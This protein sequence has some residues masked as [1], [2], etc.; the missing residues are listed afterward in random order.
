MFEFDLIQCGLLVLFLMVLGEVI[1]HK[2][3]AVVPSILASAVLYLILVWSH[4]LP[5]SVIQD[6]GLIHLTSIAMMFVI[7][8]MGISTNLLELLT[9]WRVVALAALC[10]IC[11][12]GLVILIISYIFDLNTA[13]GGLPGGAA[14]ALIVQERAKALGH[15]QIVVL[16]VL[17]LAV[18]G[19]VACP[20]VSW[21]LR[22][23]VSK[24]LKFGL[25]KDMGTKESAHME[26]MGKDSVSNKQ[27]EKSIS[28]PSENAKRNQSPYWSLLRFYIGAW[29]AARLE[30]YTGI[31]RYVFC[32]I[33]GILLTRIGFFRKD[34]MDK[35]KSNGFLTLMMM[36]MVFNGFSGATPDMFLSLL[37]PLCC[38][39][40]VDV[41]TIFLV[42]RLIGHF[43]GF[44][45][46]MRFAI[47]LNV[48]VGFPLNLMLAQD[49]IEF[50]A[51]TEEEK[52]ILNTKIGTKMVIAGF[53]SVTFLSTVGAGLLAE[54]MK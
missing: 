30:L 4:I 32:L 54:F 16:S 2:L 21:M 34:E 19:L 42:S 50:L 28:S 27:S 9:N 38:I 6:S 49:I 1:S 46:P 43:F 39:L 11:Q 20:L 5:A 29:I 12:T 8:G 18:Q 25:I 44:S 53:T 7:L 48:M 23:E 52:A 31:S 51:D 45:N 22:K 35:S 40:F 13:I 24:E 14:V 3:K 36:T 41:V 33:L 17:L 15:E 37:A 47:G 26:M 10:Y